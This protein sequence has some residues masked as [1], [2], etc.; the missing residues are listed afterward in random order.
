MAHEQNDGTVGSDPVP[1]AAPQPGG[2]A[3]MGHEIT[4]EAG[5]SGLLVMWGPL[6]IVGFLIFVFAGHEREPMLPLEV[7]EQTST[8]LV[9]ESTAPIEQP[10]SME[11][12]A[13]TVAP[14]ATST[15]TASELSEAFKAAGLPLPSAPSEPAPA[16][17]PKD[18]QG[19]PWTPQPPSAQAPGAPPPPGYAQAPYGYMPMPPPGYAPM[20]YGYPQMPG[21][22]G[23]AMGPGYGRPMPGYA[24][25][26]GYGAGPH[27][28]RPGYGQMMP[29]HGYYHPYMAPGAPPQM[30]MAA[31]P[32]PPP[33]PST[34]Q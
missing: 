23:G 30:P 22:G 24:A 26:P 28:G 29:G 2:A 17:L 4:E 16:A 1:A 34:Q 20:P 10:A 21:Y 9:T 8:E 14:A 5:F 19:S 3:V 11:T 6:I 25:P 7:V 32:S 31:P 13:E 33:P 18:L 15:D 27:M 12:A